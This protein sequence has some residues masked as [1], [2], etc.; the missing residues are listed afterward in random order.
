MCCFLLFLFV[1]FYQLAKA[2]ILPSPLTIF[3]VA[4]LSIA[5]NYS[6]PMFNLCARTELVD[7]TTSLSDIPIILTAETSI[8]SLEAAASE[9]SKK[10]PN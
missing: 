10:L 4:L 7:Q 8:T 9:D 5:S 1:E 6:Q 2:F 3:S